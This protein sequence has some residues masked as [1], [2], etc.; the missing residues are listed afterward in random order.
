MY[1]CCIAMYIYICVCIYICVY[2]SLSLSIYIYVRIY[3]CMYLSRLGL[4]ASGSCVAPATSG[5]SRALPSTLPR[6]AD[7]S[8][9]GPPEL[10]MDS[11][12][13]AH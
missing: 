4:N 7:L 2:L 9:A 13:K 11:G 3:I 10:R 6:R 1:I 5:P 12:N 8:V